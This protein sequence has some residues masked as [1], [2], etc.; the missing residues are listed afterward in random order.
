MTHRML[1]KTLARVILANLI[2]LLLSVACT[3]NQSSTGLPD[4]GHPKLDSQL[5]QLIKADEEGQAAAFAGQHNIQLPDGK[6]RVIVEALPGQLQA[7][8][9]AVNDIGGSLET[10][11]ADLLQAVVPVAGL[12]ALADKSGIRFISLPQAALPLESKP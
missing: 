3:A 12:T 11:Y 2:V 6:V 9:Q 4:K 1:D 8:T 7:A 5:N 10:S